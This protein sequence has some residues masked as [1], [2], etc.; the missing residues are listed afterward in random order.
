[1]M[2]YDTGSHHH[3]VYEIRSKSQYQYAAAWETL[4]Y[5]LYM[6]DWMHAAN[7]IIT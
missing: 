3:M 2:H 4:A 5:A 1:M 6:S 7:P